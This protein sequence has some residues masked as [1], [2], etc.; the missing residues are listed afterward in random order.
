MLVAWIWMKKESCQFSVVSPSEA[1]F[2]C[3]DG[4]YKGEKGSSFAV[5]QVT[6]VLADYL[7]E[8]MVTGKIRNSK[9]A[10]EI[11]FCPD[12]KSPGPTYRNLLKMQE[13]R[14]MIQSLAGVT[15]G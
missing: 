2:V 8:E 7:K 15:S 6:A 4:N 13:K 3:A 9:E 5:P 14:D 1:V 11:R 10:E 12:P